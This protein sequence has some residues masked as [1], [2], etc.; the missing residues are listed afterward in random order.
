MLDAMK[1]D[2]SKLD[3]PRKT[4]W[5]RMVERGF[6][7]KEVSI[8]AGFNPAYVQQ[9]IKRR[10]PVVLPEHA[11]EAIG[12]VLDLPPDALRGDRNSVAQQFRDTVEAR[13]KLARKVAADLP[14]GA[15]QPAPAFHS[16]PLDVP[17]MGT[18]RGDN[19]GKGDF[20][21]NGETVAY[22]RRLPGTS[23]YKNAFCLYVQGSSMSPWREEGSL[24]YVDPNRPARTGDHVVVELKPSSDGEAG[25]A[26]LK[27][28]VGRSPDGSLV[29][30]QYNPPNDKIRV[31][32]AKIA[33]VFRVLEWEELIG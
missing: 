33:R 25:A 17:V 12:A 18:V 31:P 29:L 22:A 32:G 30:K 9:Y 7:A 3:G 20:T 28:L 23:G 15:P 27:K 6:N 24:V 14:L 13:E 2:L 5:E 19:D 26:W 1:I 21:F 11:R 4:L 8:K 16:L 10:T